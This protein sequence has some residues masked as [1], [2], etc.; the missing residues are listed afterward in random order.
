MMQAVRRAIQILPL[1]SLACSVTL[2]SLWA[3]SY[4][5]WIG[6]GYVF[7]DFTEWY[8]VANCGTFT[9]VRSIATYPGWEGTISMPDR[10]VDWAVEYPDGWHIAGF[11][12]EVK[13]RDPTWERNHV[14]VW[15]PLW[16]PAMLG[17]IVPVLWWRRKRRASRVGFPVEVAA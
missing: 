15:C 5:R 8:A 7:A 16:F 1:V 13:R 6:G 17:A 14:V 3:V 4:A 10:A 12:G 9:A 2:C 11:G